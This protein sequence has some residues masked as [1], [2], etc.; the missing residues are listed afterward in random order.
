MHQ[1]TDFTLSDNGR[2][3]VQ[4]YYCCTSRYCLNCGGQHTFASRKRWACLRMQIL[5]ENSGAAALK[6][7][8]HIATH[9]N[10]SLYNKTARRNAVKRVDPCV[11]TRGEY[12]KHP[13]RKTIVQYDKC[14]HTSAIPKLPPL[15][16]L[17]QL[18][19]YAN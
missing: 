12:G 17:V 2:C 5:V 8:L 16:W 19:W 6:A 14:E 3:G 9:S 4:Y 15:P 10:T 18:S 13:I 7:T 1:N 11:Q